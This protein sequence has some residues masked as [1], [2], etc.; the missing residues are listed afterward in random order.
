MTPGDVKAIGADV[1][2]HRIILTYEAEAQ[3]MTGD[4]IVKRIFDNVPVP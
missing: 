2:R 1:L 3:G 4:T